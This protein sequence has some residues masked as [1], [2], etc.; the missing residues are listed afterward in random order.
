MFRLEKWYID[1]LLEDTTVLLVYIG[2]IRM[3]PARLVRV[4]ANLFFADGSRISGTSR[5][6]YALDGEMLRW[7]TRGLSGELRF[8]PRYPSVSL[9]EPLFEKAG[10]VLSWNVEVP[11]ADVTGRVRWPGGE[12]Q[13]VGRGY[14]DR[15]RFD[16]GPW[17]LPLSEL[18]WG[19]AVAGPHAA[20]WIDAHTVE[21]T[22]VVATWKDGVLAEGA[23][24]SV[25]L[26]DERI[27]V[28]GDV[29]DLEG[30]RLGALRPMLRAITR[31]PRQLKMA[32][33]A[34]MDGA[35]GVAVHEVV[36]WRT[37]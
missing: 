14:R 31:N 29:V 13:V 33:R 6:R 37:T 27:L 19:R 25:D 2:Q 9:R 4:T 18:V 26:S 1:T 7:Q 24:P 5:T 23:A 22:R 28:E 36:R 32:A 15:V 21:G 30:L 17:R 3:G 11:D 12:R 34:R 10:R 35:A 16:F 20:M 8:V